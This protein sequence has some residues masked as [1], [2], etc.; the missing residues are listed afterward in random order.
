MCVCVSIRRSRAWRQ[1]AVPGGSVLLVVVHKKGVCRALL[2]RAWRWDASGDS[3]R[4]VILRRPYSQTVCG[5]A[6]AHAP[7]RNWSWTKR[8]VSEL[9]SGA[10]AYLGI[11]PLFTCLIFS[12]A[13]FF[14]L[15]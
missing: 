12:S 7:R 10:S 6:E 1:N 14:S 2:S 5:D 3:A 4:L 13:N 11:L 15:C 8:W 9:R